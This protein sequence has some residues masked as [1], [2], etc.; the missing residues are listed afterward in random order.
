MAPMRRPYGCTAY[1]SAPADAVVTVKRGRCEFHAKA[2][3]AGD[4][5]LRRIIVVSDSSEYE[6]MTGDSNETRK[7]DIV[8]VMVPDSVGQPLLNMAE[9]HEMLEVAL[10]PFKP[11]LIDGS[12]VVMT[13]LATAFV[14]LGAYVSTADL[15]KDSAEEGRRA[16]A[17]HVFSM[18]KSQPSHMLAKPRRSMSTKLRRSMS[19]CPLLLAAAC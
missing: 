10:K 1:T 19:V 6:V 16:E 7:I 14:A 2:R 3:L 5:G 15:W 8:A 9:N 13:L 11:P 18:A 17:V 12:E 4:A